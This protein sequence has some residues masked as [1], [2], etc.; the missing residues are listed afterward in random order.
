MKRIRTFPSRS[1]LLLA[2]L[3]VLAVAITL[4]VWIEV[5]QSREDLLKFVES[6]AEVLIET[7]NRSTATTVAVNAEL[8]RAIIGRLQ[9]AARLVDARMEIR[10]SAALTPLADEV[11]VDLILVFDRNGGVIAANLPGAPS[12]H[13]LDSSLLVSTELIQPVLNGDY[14]W[15]AQGAMSTPW[16]EQKM[17][18]FVQERDRG[19]GAV[20]LGI[21]ASSMLE[22]RMRL[23][24]GKLLRDIGTSTSIE[25]VVLQDEAGILTASDGVLE[26]STIDSDPFLRSA[27]YSDSTRSRIIDY[28][29]TPA[30]EVVKPLRVDDE[31]T[32]L[33]RIGLSLD[34]V[35]TI[36]Q[37]SMHRVLFIAAG[38][39]ITAAILLVLLHTRQRFGMLQQEH[40]KVRGYTELVLDN[41]ADAV[42]ATDALGIITVFNQTAARL[43]SLRAEEVIGHPCHE[44]CRNDTLLL[45][46]TH[47]SASAIPY[48]ET[49]LHLKSGDQRTLA[50]STSVIHDEGGAVETIVAIARDVTEQRRFQEQLQRKDRVTAMGELAGGIAHEIRN[51]LN[52]I[53]IIAQRFQSEFIP[54]RDTEEYLQLTRTV[55]SEVQRVNRIITQFLEFARPPQLTLERCGVSVLLRESIE[56]VRSQALK[57]DVQ[58]ELDIEEEL[59]VM[60][61]WGKMQQVLMNIFQN[62]IEALVEGGVI[63][64]A[65]KRHGAQVA[66]II[67]DNGP[68]ISEEIRKKIFNLYFTTKA[69]GTGLGLSIVHQIVSE[70]GGEITVDSTESGGSSFQILLPA[71]ADQTADTMFLLE[72]DV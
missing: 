52:A 61:D 16:S 55:R 46:R 9:L 20:L 68:G 64:V 43:F 37:R 42:I 72:R 28:A 38:F 21:A 31:G 65:A 22:M 15:L 63:E 13:A 40:R 25:Y 34:H 41:I 27:F 71:A 30:F 4:F 10:R 5:S 48:E 17:Y 12:V 62:G 1:K 58:I 70:H 14:A 45:Q 6:E 18:I 49:L 36:Q 47:G 67:A 69:T 44:V 57:N 26:M 24:I 11:F 8:E 54:A 7:V 39:F 59:T 50:V 29:E 32:V 66:I 51:P 60:A 2:G 3:A 19:N 23:G 53:N 35:R 33:M 56:V